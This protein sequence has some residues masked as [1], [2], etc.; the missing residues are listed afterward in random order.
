MPPNKRRDP[1]ALSRTVYGNSY[2]MEIA[3]ALHELGERTFTIPELAA[4]V[5][6]HPDRIREV[7][8][9]YELGGLVSRTTPEHGPARYKAQKSPVW[10][11]AAELLAHALR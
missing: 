7:L 1:R 10:H 2:A 9:K 6:L 8:R 3:A 4:T 11:G 5:D